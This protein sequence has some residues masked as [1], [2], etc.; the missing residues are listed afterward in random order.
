MNP[1]YEFNEARMKKGQDDIDK[2]VEEYELVFP[3]P[4]W[5]KLTWFWSCVM[6]LPS[7]GATW[8][9]AK[10]VPWLFSACLIVCCAFSIPVM[11]Q[12]EVIRASFVNTTLIHDVATTVVMGLWVFLQ[13]HAFRRAKGWLCEPSQSL[14]WMPVVAC[15]LRWS[16]FLSQLFGWWTI[17]GFV[18]NVFAHGV[19][20]YL[21]CEEKAQVSILMQA[22]MRLAILQLTD[23]GNKIEILMAH[24]R[25][26]NYPNVPECKSLLGVIV[27]AKFALWSTLDTVL[28]IQ[29]ERNTLAGFLLLRILDV[30]VMTRLCFTYV[31]QVVNLQQQIPLMLMDLLSIKSIRT[32][33]MSVQMPSDYNWLFPVFYTVMVCCCQIMQ[34]NNFSC[35]V[36]GCFALLLSQN[37]VRSMWIHCVNRRKKAQLGRKNAAAMTLQRVYRGH[38]GRQVCKAMRLEIYAATCITPS[39]GPIKNDTDH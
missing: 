29:H 17:A 12:R 23:L 26:H 10:I 25:L 19:V 6:V 8:V 11:W 2:A 21:H 34:P 5:Q 1:K 18:P 24:H 4:P 28:H 16:A 35:S 33:K 22:C 38:R 14:K 30:I 36:I 32:V 7:V 3:T 9:L 20:Q 37:F 15:V 27:S 13:P 39:R 31:Q